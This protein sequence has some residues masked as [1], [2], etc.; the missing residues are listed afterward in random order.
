MSTQP[1]DRME[2]VKSAI[3]AALEAF[4]YDTL[5]MG[6]VFIEEIAEA[7]DL[8]DLTHQELADAATA[9]KSNKYDMFPRYAD[10][11]SS[12]SYLWVTPSPNCK[13]PAKFGEPVDSAYIILLNNRTQVMTREDQLLIFSHPGYAAGFIIAKGVGDFDIKSHTWAELLKS[14]FEEVIL[15]HVVDAPSNVIKLVR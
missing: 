2:A 5:T 15:D 7:T 9:L 6:F 11:F 13:E 14:P 10:E 12:R 4:E 8:P 3:A 1:T